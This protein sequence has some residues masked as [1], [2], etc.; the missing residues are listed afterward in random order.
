MRNSRLALEPGIEE[1]EARDFK[2]ERPWIIIL[3]FSALCFAE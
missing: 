2:E 3:S 1:S